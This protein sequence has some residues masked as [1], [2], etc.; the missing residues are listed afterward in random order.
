VIFGRRDVHTVENVFNVKY[1]FNN[2]M[3]FTGRVRHYWSRLN[4]KELFTLQQD[5][6]LEKNTTYTG[7]VNPDY[8]DFTVDAV[9]TWEFAPGSFINVVW[10][11]NTNYFVQTPY[12]A[13]NSE[14][15]FKNFNHTMDSPQNNNFS[16]KVIYFLDYLQLKNKKKQIS[17]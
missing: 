5:G 7:D 1:S 11:N 9:F 4:Y 10:K 12:G 13:L 8:N 17:K 16:I 3:V 6:G 15:Y 14:N 2:K